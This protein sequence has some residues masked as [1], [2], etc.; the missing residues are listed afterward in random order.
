LIIDEVGFEPMSWQEAS[1]FYR[2]VGHRYQ[3]GSIP[4][5]TNKSIKDWQEILAGDEALATA[6]LDRLL[7]NS[8][9]L[10]IKRSYRLRISSRRSAGR[11]EG[12]IG[13]QDVAIEG[14]ESTTDGLS[15]SSP[16]KRVR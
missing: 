7:H 16:R 13:K 15:V 2:L 14:G 6:I 1:L 5:T 10:N 11:A 12:R 8:H 9:V 4:I 3:R